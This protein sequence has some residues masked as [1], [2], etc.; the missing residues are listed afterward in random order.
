LCGISSIVRFEKDSVS[1]QNAIA[2]ND[3]ISHRGPDG[4]GFSFFNSD[5][6]KEDPANW[7][8]MLAQRRLAILDLSDTGKQPMAY[9]NENLWITFNGEIYNYL[10]L[11]EEL[12]R[13][14]CR[15]RGSS[16]TEVILA[17]YQQWGPAC[18]ARMR[19]MW[20]LV[21]WDVKNQ[22]LTV[23]R[24]R[25]GIKPLYYYS[26]PGKYLA[27]ASEIK[28]F[29]TLPGFKALGD[30]AVIR[31]YLLTGFERTDRTF[32]KEVKPILPGTY[33]IF[34]VRSSQ[35]LEPI[36][37]WNP[38]NIQ[39]E[40]KD[41]IE[42]AQIFGKELE[43]SVQIHLRSDV[44][45]G[46]QLS[47][48][49]DSSSIFSLMNENYKG[50]A[51]HSFTVSFPGYEKDESPFVRRML[52]GTNTT[53]H[54][55][56]PTA[57]NFSGE[58]QKFVWHH[59]E[60]VG[61]FAHY[62]GFVLARLIGEQKIKVVLNGQG[63]DE[64]LG[65]YWQQYFSYLR[66]SARSLQLGTV[67]SNV[68]G[69][70]GSDGN[71]ELV[72]QIPGMLRRYR[73]R[74]SNNGIHFSDS[75]EK[76]EQLNYM[77]AYFQLSN[78]ARRVFDIRQLILPR[79]LKWDDRNLMA[80]SVEGRYPF[81]DH[82]VIEAALRF[83]N[84]VLFQKGWTKYPLRLAMKEKMPK[85]IYYRK[86]KWGFETPQQQWLAQTLKPVL[87]DWIKEKDMPLLQIISKQSLEETSERFWKKESLEDAQLLFR[88]YLLNQWLTRFKVSFDN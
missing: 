10:E 81:L 21:I 77:S 20:S 46:C 58:I 61:S 24:D 55:V 28:Q 42:A 85:E 33:R 86:S 18:F 5:S 69:A 29:T 88:L 87:T 83:D 14:G 2:F 47:G 63:G 43:Y 68:V 72:K 3:I 80:F 66:N 34:D 19:G 76:E 71:E 70:L 7:D 51:V 75:F 60:P 11:K 82:R 64:I 36:S 13:E 52:E 45:V 50:E 73:S 31:Q 65:G 59:D 27:L 23:S 26:I 25:L 9:Q 6:G 35:W 44:P 78:Q 15:F 54:F 16:D 37:Y 22:L 30:K 79:L 48:G 67:L 8:V 32:F 41:P 74:T 40:I 17:A 1:Q 12:L 38:E 4:E 39:P 57:D 56:T 62:A 53:P 49:V 84:R